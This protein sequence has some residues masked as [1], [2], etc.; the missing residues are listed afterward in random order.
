MNKNYKQIPPM[1]R[2]VMGFDK[3][4][5]I[6][7]VKQDLIFSPTI[8]RA[9]KLPFNYE[10]TYYMFDELEYPLE[11][12][13]ERAKH[14]GMATDKSFGYTLNNDGFEDL[15]STILQCAKDYN[16]EILWYDV[17]EWRLTQSWITNKH[18]GQ[19]HDE[20]RHP[21]S[22][23]SGILYFHEKQDEELEHT[24]KQFSM[25]PPTIFC[26]EASY[27]YNTQ[28]FVPRRGGVDRPPTSY[29]TMPYIPGTLVLF[30]SELFHRVPKNESSF[31]R[32]SLSVNIVP[33]VGFGQQDNM[34]QCLF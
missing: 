20:H 14:Y 22:I 30:P 7:L 18:S 19:G 23:I 24:I 34:S 31:V 27:Y 8:I 11:S 13:P 28:L 4:N 32:K 5:E 21:N 16:H 15:S 10:T 29:Y 12:D 17:D 26:S 3:P 2:N 25:M 33:Q 1:V 9:Y 6:D